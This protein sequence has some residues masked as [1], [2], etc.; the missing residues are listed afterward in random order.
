MF[1]KRCRRTTETIY[2]ARIYEPPSKKKC[3]RSLP[4]DTVTKE[5]PEY[6]GGKRVGP[7]EVPHVQNLGIS[8]SYDD[9]AKL[10]RVHYL[11][12]QEVRKL[13]THLSLLVP[14]STGLNIKVRG[15]FVVVE[16]T[17][18]YLDTLD[19]PA[20]DLKTAYEVLSRGCEIRDRLE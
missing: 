14:G 1:G 17:V 5:I 12:W 19:S 11:V 4:S 15:N 2:K 9:K 10:L 6:Y 3:E 18:G 16:S 8:S 13:K 7:G 20:T